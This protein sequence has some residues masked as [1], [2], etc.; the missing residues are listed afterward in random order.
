VRTCRDGIVT[1]YRA[2]K[3]IVVCAGAI[4]SPAL[5]LRSGLGP[6][7]DLAALGISPVA[8]S[9]GIGRNFHDHVAIMLSKQVRAS[10][11][12]TGMDPLRLLGHILNYAL[13]K[14]GRLASITVQSVGY[15]RSRP[16]LAV[17][18]FALNFL[19]L[20]IEFAGGKPQLRKQNGISIAA[21]PARPHGRGQI[22]LR[23]ANPATPP[24]IAH[25][26][27]ADERDIE[28]LLSACALAGRIFEA[29]A[30]APF[31]IGDY[32]PMPRGRA[33]WIAY[34][35][36]RASIGFHP[37]GSCRMGDGPMAVTAPDLKVRHVQNLRV[38]D[39]SIMPR[40]TS[41][42]T[43][44]PTIMIAEKAAEMILADA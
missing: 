27:L 16:E 39:A 28:T 9:P 21:H 22:K 7:A 40:I 11:Y 5:L 10:T 34:L 33:E 4:G 23:D 29:P 36:Q 32:E 31:M 1:E 25:Q 19:P 8:D 35:R 15:G 13:F 26:L 30:L 42:N 38:A 24:L 14:R 12:N 17:P 20:A 43:N 3:E 37:V 44:A 2:R 41:G 18:D 6:A